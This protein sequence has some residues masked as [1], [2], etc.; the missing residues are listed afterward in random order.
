MVNHI[1]L[2]TQSKPLNILG[3]F[4]AVLANSSAHCTT[5]LTAEWTM[6]AEREH[7]QVM[8]LRTSYSVLSRWD[9]SLSVQSFLLKKSVP[10][11]P[12]LFPKPEVPSFKCLSGIIARGSKLMTER[13]DYPEETAT[14]INQRYENLRKW[15]G[16]QEKKFFS[17]EY[18]G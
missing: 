15:W 2:L 18:I 17:L 6:K 3:H 5:R 8:A 16:G 10:C 13:L 11:H 1:T 7:I 4:S 14:A 9:T 12:L